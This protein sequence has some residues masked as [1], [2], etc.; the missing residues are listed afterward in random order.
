[1]N[2]T[3]SVRSSTARFAASLLVIAACKGDGGPPAAPPPTVGTLTVAPQKVPAVFEFTAEAQPSH[4]VEVRSLV[5]GTILERYFVEGSDVTKGQRLFLIDPAIYEADSRTS[6]ASEEMAKATYEQA[7]RDLA[8]GEALYKGGAISQ[9]EYDVLLTRAQTAQADVAGSA[10][11]LEK[12][13]VDL[14]RTT[15]KAEISGRIG[16]ANLLT[17]AQ[18]PGP[19]V[20]LATIDQINP[21]YVDLAISDNDRL[22][23]EDDVRNKRIT[24][25][26]RGS[27]RVQLVLSDGTEFE[28]EGRINFT[29]LRIDSETGSLR[30][31]T[32]FPNPR[33]RILPGQFVRARLLGA[34]RNNAIVVPQTAVQQAL[35]RQ[36]VYVVVGDTA[37]SRDVKAGSWIGSDWIIEGGL[38]PGDRV[39]VDNIQRVRAGSPVVAKEWMKD[40]AGT[41]EKAATAEA[42]AK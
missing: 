8:R 40:S 10:A 32:V 42:G 33:R 18:V 41:V 24:T 37:R 21:I 17:G 7:K 22:K 20:L 1:V 30:L 12:A 38:N 27:Y 31:R 5:Q 6:A 29:D 4:Q 9:R 28:H 35:G 11:S 2:V 34:T 23:Y 16:Q 25:P 39:I 3:S 14:R 19:S 15:I 26:V 36:F 13:N